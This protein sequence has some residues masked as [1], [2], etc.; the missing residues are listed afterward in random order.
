MQIQ[1]ARSVPVEVT[2][3]VLQLSGLFDVPPMEKSELAWSAALPIEERPWSVGLI[4][5]PSGCGKSTIARELFGGELV[6]GFE[7]PAAKSIV[8]AFPAEMGIKDITMLLS[9]VGFSSPPSWL[10][11]FGVLSTG[12][13]FRVTVARAMAEAQERL[14]VIDEFT[15]V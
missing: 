3:R 7:W 13:Q 14:F 5:G 12:E 4:V 10:R 9:S 1:I 6:Q 11:P 2:P 8:D 15:S